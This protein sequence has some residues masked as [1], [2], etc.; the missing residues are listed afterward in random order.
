[1]ILLLYFISGAVYTYYF[2]QAIPV[3]FYYSVLYSFVFLLS[4]LAFTY[5]FST[6]FKNGAVALTIVAILYF[7]VFNIIDGVSQ[8]AGVEPWF[9]ITYAANIITLVFAGDY[10]GDYPHSTVIHAGRGLTI[11][12]YNPY[13]WEGVAIMLIYFLISAILATLIFKW[14]ELK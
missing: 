9:S 4:L 8:I 2:H 7:F 13:I 6:F 5:L 12:A 11:T 14:K 3:E 10:M 1:M